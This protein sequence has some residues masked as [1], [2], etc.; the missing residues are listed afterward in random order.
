M[1]TLLHRHGVDVEMLSLVV[2]P[3]KWL[4]AQH[5]IVIE[6]DHKEEVSV[7]LHAAIVMQAELEEEVWALVLL[8]ADSVLLHAAIVMQAE[9]E[10]EV[11]ALVLLEAD[12]SHQD[13]L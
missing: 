10:E 13:T 7:L 6:A 4:L 11:W 9:F 3:L 8:E 5:A 2:T 12:L 1:V